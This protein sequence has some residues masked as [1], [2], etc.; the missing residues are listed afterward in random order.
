MALGTAISA[1]GLGMSAVGAYSSAQSQ[2]TSAKYNAA[3]A[4]NN[5]EISR[6]NADDIEKRGRV[7]VFDQYRQIASQLSSVEA[8][9]AGAGL[10]VD[11]EGTTG[12]DLVRAMTEAG[13]LD[14]MRLKN[15]IQREKRRA[16]IQGANFEAQA[17]Q[18]ETT[19]RSISP[20]RSGLVALGQGAASPA[21][22]D[23]LD[24]FGS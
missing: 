22:Q 5:A 7:A 21:G 15:N 23:I 4:R 9:T 3:V 1:I 18:L 16:L 2:K 8:A 13:A 24:L 11:V 17:G 6:D 19:A 10:E 20:F 14:V 12:Q